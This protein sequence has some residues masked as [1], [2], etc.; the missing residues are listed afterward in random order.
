MYMSICEFLKIGTEN[1]THFLCVYRETV[2]H[3][4]NKEYPGKICV[5]YHG[6]HHL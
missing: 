3:F 4:E 1:A 5:P 6:V 2:Q